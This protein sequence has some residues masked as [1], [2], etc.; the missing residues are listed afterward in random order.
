METLFSNQFSA[1]CLT[2]QN[3]VSRIVSTVWSF[4]WYISRITNSWVM[5][6]VFVLFFSL[7]VSSRRFCE[8]FYTKTRLV[9]S[10]KRLI[11]LWEPISFKPFWKILYVSVSVKLPQNLFQRCHMK[12]WLPVKEGNSYHS[13]ATY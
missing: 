4:S 7:C 13:I 9:E 10:Y 2:R 12:L 1:I 11:L 6:K 5:Q 8:I 3:L